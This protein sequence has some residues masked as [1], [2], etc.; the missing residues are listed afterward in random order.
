MITM[1][2]N[3]RQDGMY[4]YHIGTSTETQA[5]QCMTWQGT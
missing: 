5:W 3:I 1:L 4:D 2:T